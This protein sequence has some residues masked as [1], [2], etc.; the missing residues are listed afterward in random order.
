MNAVLP[1]HRLTADTDGPFRMCQ[2]GTGIAADP[3]D[4]LVVYRRH[5]LHTA[6]VR[7]AERFAQ[8]LEAGDV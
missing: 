8:L 6:A 2:C 5:R 7:A 4:E 3:A 1:G